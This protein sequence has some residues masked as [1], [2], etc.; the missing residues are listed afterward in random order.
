MSLLR[1]DAHGEEAPRDGLQAALALGN[2]N[3]AVPGYRLDECTRTIVLE[4]LT[5]GP[6]HPS[7]PPPTT[8]RAYA[9][10][11]GCCPQETTVGGWWRGR[12]MDAKTATWWS[13]VVLVRDW[14]TSVGCRLRANGIVQVGERVI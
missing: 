9:K 8:R 1:N 4:K 13:G 6:L 5:L 11:L 7:R 3:E 10:R 14:R 12:D 2:V